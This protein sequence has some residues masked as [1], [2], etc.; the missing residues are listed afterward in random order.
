VNIKIK[1]SIRK[2]IQMKRA[3][4]K[5]VI[6]TGGSLGIGRETS[7]LLAKEGAKVAVTDILDEEG[8]E[9]VKEIK[10][11]G[12]VAK[13]WLDEPDQSCAKN[14]STAIAIPDRQ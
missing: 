12:G 1:S 13:F 5:V 4:N 3:E 8:L 14:G 9:L 11:S 10:Q 2:E 7:L 6:V